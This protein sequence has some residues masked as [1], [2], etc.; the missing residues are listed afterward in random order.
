MTQ[1]QMITVKDVQEVEYLAG[2]FGRLAEA[3]D[4]AA[5]VSPKTLP[6]FRRLRREVLNRLKSLVMKSLGPIVRSQGR[7]RR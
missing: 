1:R 3:V 7:G 6:E 4:L 2:Q 5:N